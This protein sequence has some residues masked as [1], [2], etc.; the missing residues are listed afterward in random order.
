M[1]LLFVLALHIR[2]VR[3][4]SFVINGPVF[5]NCHHISVWVAFIMSAKVFRPHVLFFY[6]SNKEITT[7]RA[8]LMNDGIR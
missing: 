7:F 3:Y 8:K 1:M 6:I 4:F 5:K 2:D